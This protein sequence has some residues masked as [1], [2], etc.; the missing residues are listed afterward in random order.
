M[1][2]VNA[3]PYPTKTY[4]DMQVRLRMIEGETEADLLSFY[5]IMKRYGVSRT[6]MRDAVIA[7]KVPCVWLGGQSRKSRYVYRSDVIA[8]LNLPQSEVPSQRQIP[9]RKPLETPK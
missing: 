8:Y 6:A 5:D 3:V 7:G 9:W 4:Q 2:N 1:S